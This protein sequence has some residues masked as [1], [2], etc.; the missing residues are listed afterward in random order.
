MVLG[1]HPVA[2]QCPSTAYPAE[3]AAFPYLTVCLES[4]RPSHCSPCLEL[5][6][7]GETRVVTMS[8]RKASLSSALWCCSAHTYSAT[9]RGWAAGSGRSAVS[10][11]SV[12]HACGLLA[13]QH[14]SPVGERHTVLHRGKCVVAADAE[15]AGRH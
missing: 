10:L 13:A 4:Q 3:Y 8:R 7:R 15:P 2:L 6:G 5:M 9:S 11:P 14:V 1:P 12:W